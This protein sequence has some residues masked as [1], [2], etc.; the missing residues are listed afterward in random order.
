MEGCDALDDD[1]CEA[2]RGTTVNGQMTFAAS[3]PV[4]S[5]ECQIYG[6]IL[7]V[8]V[9]FPGGCPVVDAC[10]SLSTGDCPIESGETFVYDLS[11]KI[12]NLY[13]PVSLKKPGKL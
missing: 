13:P 3:A 9:P 11:M 7:G 8:E 4:D 12:E 5:L 2:K 10:T 1:Y 6:I